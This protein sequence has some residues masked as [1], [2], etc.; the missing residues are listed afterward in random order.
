MSNSAKEL[1]CTID[2]IVS[3]P[4]AFVRINAMLNE[5]NCSMAEIADVI[6]K[7]PGLTIRILRLANSPVYGISKEIDSVHKAINIIGTEKVRDIALATSAVDTFEG[8]PNDLVSMEDFWMHSIFCAI[9]SKHL[10]TEAKLKNPDGLFVAGL[11]HDIGQLVLF[12]ALPE[13]SHKSLEYVLDDTED[14]SLS[15]VEQE[16]IGF[17]HATVGAE[18]AEH[19]QLTPMLIEVIRS[20]H[21]LTRAESY[22]QE[23]AI[24]KIANSIAVMA[25]LDSTNIDETD[26]APITENDWESAHLDTAIAD[27]IMEQA[28][29]VAHDNFKEISKL[30]MPAH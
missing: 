22:L 4:G 16:F 5:P 6:S 13:L 25:E 7:D 19:W 14:K 11:L 9:I 28:V 27:E 23:S 21:D 2:D 24:V 3:L 30:L 18:L 12:K 17:D 26:A 20:H 10:A 8:I 1:V 29:Q 15:V